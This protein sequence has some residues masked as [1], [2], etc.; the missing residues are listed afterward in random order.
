MRGLNGGLIGVESGAS[1]TSASG[2]W[3]T[4]EQVLL[5]RAGKWP[6]ASPA[7]RYY[8][9]TGFASTTLHLNT[10]DLSEIIVYDSNQAALSGITASTNISWTGGTISVAFNG[11]V[12]TNSRVYTNNWSSQRAS[13]YIDLDLGSARVIS[14]IRIYSLY[15]DTQPRFPESFT[16]AGSNTAGSGFGSAAT[17]S[18]GNSTTWTQSPAGVFDSGIVSLL[19][20]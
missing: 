14:F 17:V 10:L 6:S 12:G 16:I 9:I 1:A 4:N 15:A 3:A 5:R 18:V 20:P 19:V 13:A 8:R 11:A 2:V 7:Y